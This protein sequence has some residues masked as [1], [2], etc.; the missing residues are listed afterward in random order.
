MEDAGCR[1]AFKNYSLLR[2]EQVKYSLI[3][4][5]YLADLI[6]SRTAIMRSIE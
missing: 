2:L 5:L 6:Q 3:V 1:M 4:V